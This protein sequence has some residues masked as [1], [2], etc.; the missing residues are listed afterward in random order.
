MQ[1]SITNIVFGIRYVRSFRIPQITGQIVDDVLRSQ[2]SP[3]DDKVFPKV[4]EDVNGGRRLCSDTGESWISVTK[5]DLVLSWEIT[6]FKKD[7]DFFKT[8]LLP[9]MVGLISDYNISRISRFGTIFRHKV[10]NRQLAGHV[11]K[12]LTKDSISDPNDFLARFSKKLPTV[13][14]VAIKEKSDYR[15]VIYTFE[16]TDGGLFIDIDYQYLFEP[17]LGDIRA[18]ALSPNDFFLSAK[19]F[20][21]DQ[22]K[23]IDAVQEK[24]SYG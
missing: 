7:F 19:R 6:D 9:Y 22:Y 21:E 14:G 3:F 10:Q 11:A 16:S 18:A 20:V 2:K 23:W 13:E 5:D 24:R 1:D 8:A 15:N 4:L 12:Q 17:H